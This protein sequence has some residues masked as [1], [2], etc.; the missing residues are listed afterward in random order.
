MSR[1]YNYQGSV[2]TLGG[3]EIFDGITPPA[4]VA[5]TDN[6][7]S[8][9]PGFDQ[10]SLLLIS[11]TKNLNLSGLRSVLDKRQVTLINIG[12]F[13]TTLLDD[14]NLSVLN[15]RFLLGANTN[16]Q[17]LQAISL[18][19]IL[20]KGWVPAGGGGSGGAGL[21]LTDGTTTVPNVA[22]LVIVGGAVADDG[23]GAASLIIPQS[24]AFG[25][26]DFVAPPDIGSWTWVDQNLNTVASIYGGKALRFISPANLTANEQ[27]LFLQ[28]LASPEFTLT[29][30]FMLSGF[31]IQNFSGFGLV[32]RDSVTTNMETFIIDVRTTPV[33]LSAYRYTGNTFESDAFASDEPSFP[34]GLLAIPIWLRAVRDV[35]GDI[36]FLYSND[37]V[38]FV[39]VNGGAQDT[40]NFVA[41]PDQIGVTMNNAGTLGNDF[42]SMSAILY[43]FEVS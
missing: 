10:A 12:A 36:T 31:D 30:C 1:S 8:S 16:L 23:S 3:A 29:A 15:N 38:V 35:S 28:A 33:G 27:G 14:S 41:N 43:S 17:P 39:A 42:Q 26:P 4:L 22:E 18:I 34:Q 6:Y 13:I 20:G 25:Q 11:S 19:S 40:D 9:T 5:D 7:S 2:V 21:T 24:L 32:W 37:G